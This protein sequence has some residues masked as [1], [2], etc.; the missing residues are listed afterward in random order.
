M[1]FMPEVLGSKVYMVDDV[2]IVCPSH[3]SMHVVV[4][5][6]IGD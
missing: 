5:Y 1:A 3:L 2:L 6:C 4:D